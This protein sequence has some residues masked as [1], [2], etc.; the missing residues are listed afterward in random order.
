MK[1]LSFFIIS[2][3][4]LIP[5][6]SLSQVQDG[7]IDDP[8]DIV[9]IAYHDSVDGFA[10]LFMDDCPAGTTIKFTDE[11]WNGTN[12]G[13]GE[14]DLTWTN[15]TGNTL[16]KGT[17]VTIT[18]AG[19]NTMNIDIGTITESDS[20]FGT[21]NGDQI[22][23]MTGTRAAPGTFLAF[24]GE[25]QT[26]NASETAVLTGTGLTAGV[27]AKLTATEAYYNDITT[28]NGT[29]VDA[30]TTF[31]S[32]T[33]LG[34]SG[35]IFPSD[36]ISS[37]N[38]TVFVP[39]STTP[40]VTTLTASSIA[41]TT[42]T[43]SG[44]VTTNG[45]ASVSERGI[46]YSITVANTNPEIGGSGTIKKSN[47]NGIGSFSESITG[48]T[49]GTQYSFKAY[50]INIEGTSYGTTETFTLSKADQ[51]LTFDAL[52]PKTFG[53]AP[54]A[55]TANASSGLSISY[56]SSNPTV[57]TISGSTVTIVGVGTTNITASQA[58]DSA[59]NAAPNVTQ[60]LTVSKADQT[61]TFDALNP[62]TFGDAPF[63]LTANA[64]S[65]LSISYVSSNPTVATVSGS[66]VTIVGVGTT[67]ITASQ[68]GDA[69]YNAA[70]NV[71]QSLTVSKADQTL[72]FGAL[73][74]KTF[75]DAPF[76]LTANA[77]SGLSISY[78][79]SNPTVATVSGS[80]VTIVGVG[81]TNITASQ[82]GDAAYNAAPNVTQS[83]TVSKADQT[84]TFGALNSKTF[85]DAP[86]A[87]TA[88]ASSGLS[89]SYVSSNPTV[90]TVSGSTVTIVGVGTTNITASQAGDAAYNA[91]PNVTQSLT[92]SK[93]DQTLT[94]GALNSKTF[95]DAPFALTANASSG[96]S[97]SY[98]SSN[99]TVATVSGSTVTIVGVGTTNITAS[100]AGDAAYNAAPNVTQ[101]LTV[102][103]ADQTLTFGAL[104]SKTF[105]DAPFALTANASSGLSI[106]YVS[107]NPTVA[108][109]SGSTVTIVGVGTTNITASQ[110]G[111]AA[112]NAAPNVTQSL[113]VSKA[114]QTL[115]FG[116][117]NSKTF[118]DAPFA[119]TANAS[120]GLSISYVSS[121]P[122]VA[123]VSGSTVTIVGVGTTNITASQAGDA[124]YNAA[125]NV[126][127]A[128]TVDKAVLTITGL[129][130]ED[131]TYD[132]TTTASV[133]G[134][135]ILSGV[136]GLDNVSLNGNPVYTFTS[137]NIGQGIAIIT[138]GF[139][140]SGSDSGNYTLIQPSL[141]ADITGAPITIVDIS[142]TEVTCSGAADGSAT[143]SVSGG[144]T[145]YSYEWS[146]GE[147]TSTNI[148]NTLEGGSHSVTIFD[149]LNNSVTQ[150]FNINEGNPIEATVTQNST[151]YFGYPPASNTTIGVETVQGGQGSYTYLW[152]TGENTQNIHV[153][154]TETTTYSVLITDANGCSITADILVNVI[155]VRCNKHNHH[156]RKKFVKICHK[157]RKTICVPKQAVSAHLNHGDTLGQCG[158]ENNPVSITNLKIYPNP[159]KSHLFVHFKSTANATIDLIIYNHR[160]RPVFQKTLN[161]NSG[162]SKVRLNLT[163]LKRGHYY[164][165]AIVDGKIQ[166]TRHLIKR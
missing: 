38:G 166:K 88:N 151:V 51:T 102:S 142:T 13:T 35:Y 86:F 140:I 77:S 144:S 90:A 23:A 87:L 42:V 20:G 150:N 104:N 44:N 69:A 157:G 154:P 46:V 17:I 159:F 5:T 64:S 1:K 120:S 96:L 19:G 131:K 74:S 65:G 137:E 141:S 152:N 70:P 7:A 66:T 123:T 148:L 21:A 128:L 43:L 54:F 146:T 113:T 2:F 124:A 105:G 163:S 25:D 39:A 91:A 8:G 162:K 4:F 129:S 111:D 101:S 31:N 99:P 36:L 40:T 110:A 62:K 45:G 57:A 98:V 37:V 118:G 149:A 55:L 164:L 71:T 76:A 127:Q 33:W 114:D 158:S 29:V 72:T 165:K 145:P 61:L 15:N 81:T 85:G 34:G 92:V 32:T 112:Y 59:Y 16:T 6:I 132:G 9:F 126:T 138:T 108:T 80:T 160:R 58:G 79:S 67:N 133:I 18:D 27:T 130:G 139:T 161:V 12:F 122:T 3:I 78:V 73:N 117:L 50:A 63:A 82:A 135:P 48:L 100:Q 134:T 11:E 41:T 14:G 75:G 26:M 24:I 103:K 109:V 121:N 156:G 89:I 95:G 107:S 28:F 93:A 153:C 60:T 97:I 116:A 115:T 49:P 155:D 56:V 47:G 147:T 53:N 119:L 22:Y 52:N 143:V 136:L 84:L 125:P 10:F 94:F 68:A 30:A 106:S 83:L